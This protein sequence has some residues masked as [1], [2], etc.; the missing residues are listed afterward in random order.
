MKNK[1]VNRKTFF[2]VG[3]CFTS[4]GVVFLASVSRA[5][6]AAFIGLGVTYT[7]LSKYKEKK[8]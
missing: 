6:G 7:I 2:Y 5:L 1:K 8:K 4:V 3:I